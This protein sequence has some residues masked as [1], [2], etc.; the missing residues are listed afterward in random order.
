MGLILRTQLPFSTG[1]T[2]RRKFKVDPLLYGDTEGVR[3]TLDLEKFSYSGTA[4]PANNAP[5]FDL[6][7][8]ENGV[9]KVRTGSTVTRAGN[10]FAFYGTAA[11]GD[12]VEIPASVAADIQA[13]QNFLIGMHVRLPTAAEWISAAPSNAPI[14]TWTDAATGWPT[15]EL[16]HVSMTAYGGVKRIN[17]TRQTAAN[18]VQ[19]VGLPPAAA[20]FGGIVQLGY[21]RNSAG[22]GF[23]IK[24]E[25]G[26]ISATDVRGADNSLNFSAQKGKFGIGPS[27]WQSILS[28]G[29][30]TASNFRIHRLF[31]ENL[32]RSNRDPTAVLDRDYARAKTRT[33]FS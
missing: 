22:I 4:N 32:A 31:I 29:P 8:N 25:N 1:D 33:V 19:D 6:S 20:D 5:M 15:A 27:N 16:L 23:R 24:S 3:F 12:Y 10:G 13:S 7:A 28:G 18:V 14:L 17:W 21:W 26:L 2:S 11:A 9:M 30:K